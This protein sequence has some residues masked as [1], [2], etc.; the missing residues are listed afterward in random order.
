MKLETAPL[1]IEV[2]PVDLPYAQK[3]K[4]WSKTKRR[5]VGALALGL[6]ATVTNYDAQ[7]FI[8]DQMDDI[9]WTN[10]LRQNHVPLWDVNLYDSPSIEITAA[11]GE[12]K[13]HVSA[14][15]N[16]NLKDVYVS[17]AHTQGYWRGSWLKWFKQK[18]WSY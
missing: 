6:V 12:D 7:R 1:G 14:G 4:G 5:V 2:P 17:A 15:R 18:R 11:F 13:F 8:G 10:R 16:A 9:Y 3:R